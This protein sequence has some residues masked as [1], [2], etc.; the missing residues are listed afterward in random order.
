MLLQPIRQRSVATDLR[1][2]E[3]SRIFVPLSIKS[4][5]SSPPTPRTLWQPR[6]PSV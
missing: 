6:Q 1:K 4:G 2:I 5:P 3:L